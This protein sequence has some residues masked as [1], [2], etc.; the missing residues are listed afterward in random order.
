MNAIIIYAT[1]YGCT[2]RAAML[3]GAVLSEKPVVVN[4]AEKRM[5]DLAPYD[6]VILGTPIYVGKGEKSMDRFVAKNLE[7]L[8]SKRLGLF[9]CA[10][11]EDEALSNKQIEKA[12]SPELVLHASVKANLGGE[13]DY[14][15]IS[16]FTKFI[17][18]TAKGITAGYSRLS[19]ERVGVF[20]M[21]IENA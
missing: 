15:K 4:L 14:R 20:A 5:P 21:A 17:L 7:T 3:V 12:F 11:E 1:R 13:L 9:V 6:T 19:R 8:K 18:R 16:A 2:E 10:G